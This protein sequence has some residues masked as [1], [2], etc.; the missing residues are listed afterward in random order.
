LSANH[1][2]LAEDRDTAPPAEAD[3]DNAA[4]RIQ[5]QAESAQTPPSPPAEDLIALRAALDELTQKYRNLQARSAAQEAEVIALTEQRP[6]EVQP[7]PSLLVPVYSESWE[8]DLPMLPGE[9][10]DIA[11]A[12]RRRVLRRMLALGVTLLLLTL[13][14]LAFYTAFQETLT[15]AYAAALHSPHVPFALLAA[16]M[17]IAGLGLGLRAKAL[18]PALLA[19]ATYLLMLRNVPIPFVIALLLTIQVSKALINDR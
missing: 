6:L 18:V 2:E 11:P 14:M 19:L 13:G 3:E 16:S 15:R 5:D 4:S 9:P 17:V 8:H 1:P 7:M 12:S 10:I